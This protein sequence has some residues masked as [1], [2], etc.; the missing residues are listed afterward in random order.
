MIFPMVIWTGTNPLREEGRFRV[1]YRGPPRADRPD[2]V[3]FAVEKCIGLDSMKIKRWVQ[4]KD[5]GSLQVAAWSLAHALGVIL[6]VDPKRLNLDHPLYCELN[7]AVAEGRKS[8]GCDCD[9]PPDPSELA[10]E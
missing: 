5:Q 4:P 8:R 1:V 2:D 3:P 7:L 9:R 6:M 10:H